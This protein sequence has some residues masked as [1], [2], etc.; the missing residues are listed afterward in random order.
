[1][2]L[3][4]GYS[5][6]GYYIRAIEIKDKIYVI[7]GSAQN[8]LIIQNKKIKK[9]IEFEKRQSIREPSVDVIIMKNICFC[10]PTGIRI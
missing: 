5:K 3:E 1:M 9:I 8:L 2:D 6:G 10:I 7:P 4:T